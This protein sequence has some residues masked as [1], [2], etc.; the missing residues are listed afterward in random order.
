M[1]ERDKIQE[2]LM[3]EHPILDMV[4][5]NELDLQEKLKENTF[6][7]LKYLDLYNMEKMSYEELE[8]KLE[9]LMGKRYDHYRFE[10][11]KALTKVEIEKYYLPK[12]EW[13]KKTK[14]LLRNQQVRVEF[15]EM[16]VSGLKSMK[17]NMQQFGQNERMG[18]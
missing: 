2:E 12:D 17:W 16:C 7:T 14:K 8:E 13:I 15:F 3:K 18:I 6:L 5:F 1:S 11:D 9:I 4:S 10:E